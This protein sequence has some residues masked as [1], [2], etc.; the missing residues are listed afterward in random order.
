MIK[1]IINGIEL[2]I[3]ENKANEIYFPDD[4]VS[5]L[6]DISISSILNAIYEKKKKLYH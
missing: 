5:N 2:N 1:R 3:N 4:F 6:N